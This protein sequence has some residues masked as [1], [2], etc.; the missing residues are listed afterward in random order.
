MTRADL[1]RACLAEAGFPELPVVETC[2]ECP[3][4]D[5]N[6]WPTVLFTTTDVPEEQ[7]RAVWRAFRLMGCPDTHPCYS[8]WHYGERGL[9]PHSAA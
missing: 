9:C 1:L 6:G 3:M 8:C 4:C 2:R 7:S 5:C